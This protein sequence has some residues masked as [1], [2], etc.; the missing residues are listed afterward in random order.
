MHHP[1]RGGMNREVTDP[2][3]QYLID[4]IGDFALYSTLPPGT[5]TFEERRTKSAIDLCYATTGLIDQAIKS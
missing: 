3:A 2:E 4:I 5:V 1:L